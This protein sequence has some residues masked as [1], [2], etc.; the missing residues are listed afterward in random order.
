MRN[1]GIPNAVFIESLESVLRRS[2]TEIY[3]VMAKNQAQS[4]RLKVRLCLIR[5][6][7]SVL[8]DAICR[9]TLFPEHMMDNF[10]PTYTLYL[11]DAQT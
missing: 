5:S 2:F 11:D 8:L 7:P 3:C 1:C 9:L 4:E 6:L 10:Q